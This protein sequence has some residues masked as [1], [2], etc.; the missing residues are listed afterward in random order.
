[1]NI[2]VRFISSTLA[3]VLVVHVVIIASGQSENFIK[4]FEKETSGNNVEESIKF[5]NISKLSYYPDTLPSWFFEPPKS[6]LDCIYAV[7]ISDPDMEPQKAKE[8]AYYRAKAIT[9]IYLGSKLQ[10][11]R[12]VYTS[13]QESGRYTTYR[14]RFDTYFKVTSLNKTRD[15]DFAVVDSHLTRYNESLILIKYEPKHL[16]QKN[17]LLSV[18]GTVLYVEA[19][20]DD[21]FEVQAEYELRSAFM[22]PEKN[23]LSAHSLYREKG[24]KFLAYSQFLDSIHDFP[25]YIYK[26]ASSKWNK[27][28]QPLVSYNGLWSKFTREMLRYLTLETEQTRVRIKNLGEKYN[29]AM[30]NL[31]RQIVSYNAQLR[32]NGIEFANDS[33]KLKL[34]VNEIESKIE[35]P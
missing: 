33:I 17:E 31:A 32:L 28:T 13:E 3:F 6:T 23:L 10:Y 30:T 2:K 29:P 26:Y 24:N 34:V 7:G 16:E 20:V 25:V 15:C 4:A 22:Q 21:A 35:K 11:Y 19:Q 12:D 8:M 27:S 9:N 5:K 14:Q 1:M 18:T